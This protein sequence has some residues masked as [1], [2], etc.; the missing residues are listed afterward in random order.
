M[1]LFTFFTHC[2]QILAALGDVDSSLGGSAMLE[3]KMKGYPRPNVK[4]S[5]DGAPLNVD[6][7]RLKV[8]CSV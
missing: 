3:L 4:W 7:K 2:A 8:S 5:K 1:F 6:G